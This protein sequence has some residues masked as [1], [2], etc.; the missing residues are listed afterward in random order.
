MA[1]YTVQKVRAKV[2]VGSLVVRTP[3]VISFNVTRSRG[4]M[5]ATCSASLKVDH[6]VSSSQ[7][8]NI[9]SIEAGAD[10]RLLRIFTGIVYRCTINPARTDA[11]KVILNISAKDML[12]VMEGQ[13]ITRRVKDSGLAPERW[14]AVTSIL[15]RD[16]TQIM[17]V[18]DKLITNKPVGVTEIP[19]IPMYEVAKD[20]ASQLDRQIPMTSMGAPSVEKLIPEN[21]KQQGQ[22]EE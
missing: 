1:G 17:K 11:S 10:G 12:S 4:Q 7:I 22:E 19:Y 8:G 2:T 6:T 14:A 16:F 5:S 9:I 13:R 18:P 20:L 3:D 15:R 21:E